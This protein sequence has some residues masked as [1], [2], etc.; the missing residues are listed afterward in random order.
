VPLLRRADLARIRAEL[1]FYAHTDVLRA[2][3][4]SV[5]ALEASARRRYVALAVLLDDMPAPPAVQQTL[6]GGDAGQA[7]ETAE[8][9]VSL[10]LA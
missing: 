6:W 10:S 4:V 9:F 1:P 5:D 8:Q 2:I 3:Q 7:L